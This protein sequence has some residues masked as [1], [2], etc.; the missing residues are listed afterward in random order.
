MKFH[1]LAAYG[2]SHSGPFIF[3][4]AVQSLEGFEYQS[5]KLLVKSDAVVLYIYLVKSL[6]IVLS[7]D[8]DLRTF[9]LL[10]YFKALPIRF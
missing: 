9:F 3:A 8:P 10:R 5:L 6:L 1:D 7:I 2:K 4:V